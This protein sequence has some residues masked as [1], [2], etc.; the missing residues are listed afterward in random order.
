MRYMIVLWF[1]LLVRTSFCLQAKG[2]QEYSSVL[3]KKI[4]N[5]QVLL[6][7][8]PKDILIPASLVKLVTSGAILNYLGSNHRI[9]TGFYYTGENKQGV[10]SGDLIVKGGGDPTFVSEDLW[11]VAVH[12]RNL[13]FKRFAGD[14]VIDDTVFF[15]SLRDEKNITTPSV[16]KHAYDAPVSSL[17]LNFN[18]YFVTVAPGFIPGERAFVK[19]FPYSLDSVVIDN[20]VST[21]A[22]KK[23]EVIEV[24]RILLKN[25]QEKI[26][27]KG[28]I[29]QHSS[30]MEYYRSVYDPVRA[31]GEQIKKILGEQGVVVGQVVRKKPKEEGRLIFVHKS[32]KMSR[33]IEELN[34]YSNNYLADSL[35]NLIGA[36]ERRKR[37]IPYST[38]LSSYHL[39]L[40][41]IMRFMREDVGIK[42]DLVFKSG[43][44]LSPDNRLSAEQLVDFLSYMTVRFELFPDYLVSLPLA[45]YGGT[46]SKRFKSPVFLNLKGTIRAKT[47]TLFNPKVVSGLAGY[48]QH[49]KHGLVAFA[50]MQNGKLEKKYDLLSKL[51]KDQENYVVKVMKYLSQ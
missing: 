12:M 37:Q 5:K 19:L 15:G 24:T 30:L 33:I 36:V 45:G 34:Y 25:G 32:K 21:T 40:K 11:K 28:Q 49:Q 46:L 43:S 47:G 27:V 17:G 1:F 2:H 41:E 16:S 3:F 39:G 44:G 4:S 18:T 48:I 10:V 7:Q 38:E 35:V 50:I 6:S 9:E 42:T 29:Y 8:N 51:H 13:G 20:Q 26:L 23:K 31:T 22:D 14:L